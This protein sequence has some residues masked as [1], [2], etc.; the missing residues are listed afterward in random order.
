VSNLVNIQ[1]LRS[2]TITK[3]TLAV[4]GRVTWRNR[5]QVEAPSTVAASYSSGAMVCRRAR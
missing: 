4:W 3:S 2:S 5:R 1:M